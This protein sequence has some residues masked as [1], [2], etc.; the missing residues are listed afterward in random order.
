MNRELEKP[1]AI[2]KHVAARMA[3]LASFSI[4][5]AGAFP[6]VDALRLHLYRQAD[7]LAAFPESYAQAGSWLQ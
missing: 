7:A 4:V 1:K 3:I 6:R 2:L 5:L